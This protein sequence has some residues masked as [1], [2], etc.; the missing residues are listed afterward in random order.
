MFLMQGSLRQIT[1]QFQLQFFFFSK[2]LN[3]NI[4]AVTETDRIPK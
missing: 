3:Q 1:L 4:I 2:E